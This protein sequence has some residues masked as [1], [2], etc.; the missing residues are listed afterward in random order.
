MRNS[1][2]LLLDKKKNMFASFHQIYT[3]HKTKKNILKG[4]KSDFDNKKQV[5]NLK[6]KW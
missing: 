4:S 5:S 2:F 1:C 3:H 6:K